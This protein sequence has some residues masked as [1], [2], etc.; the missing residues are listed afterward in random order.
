MELRHLRYFVA[1]ADELSFTRAAQTLH[2]AQSA[3]SA[4][5]H[6]LEQQ[7]G[8]ALFDRNSRRV[9]LT[10]AGRAFQES[11]L[12]ILRAADDAV[13]HARRVGQ[14]GYGTLAVGFSGAQSHEWMPRILRRF[15]QAYPATEVTLSEMVPAVQIE[16][17]LARKLD[18][19][20]IGAVEAR[21][22]PGL[23]VECI[24]E[25]RP[26]LGIP[27]DH[28]LACRAAVKLSALRDEGFILTSRQ[29]SPSFR[30]WLA[31]FFQAGG[32]APRIVQE[33]DR[34]RTGVQYVA[35]GFGL[36]IFPEHISRLPAPGVIFLPLLGTRMK[37]RYGLAWRKGPEDET[38]ERFVAYARELAGEG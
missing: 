18:V 25:E 24:A 13:R 27:S 6:D 30:A 5:V 26:L 9:R 33:V 11:A 35:A 23:H 29:N 17:L 31:R 12:G 2:V 32:F 34:V 20:F 8:V 1:V 3:V 21:P 36:S 37:I 7:I 38:V 22:P 4:Q 28:P 15:R 14:A 16:A 19:G 10:P